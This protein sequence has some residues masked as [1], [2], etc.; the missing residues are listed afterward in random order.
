[1]TSPPVSAK[2]PPVP[3]SAPT[4]ALEPPAAARPPDVQAKKKA[5]PAKDP[6]AIAGRLRAAG[7]S[8]ADVDALLRA[9]RPPPPPPDDAD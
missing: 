3:P 2:P 4:P 5:P 8:D 7:A 6:D 1:V 9:L